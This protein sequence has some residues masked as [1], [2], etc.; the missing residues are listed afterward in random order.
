[1]E[2]IHEIGSWGDKILA[3]QKKNGKSILFLDCKSTVD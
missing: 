1:M 2:F 3:A